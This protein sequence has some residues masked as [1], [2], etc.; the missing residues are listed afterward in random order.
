V[1]LYHGGEAQ[2]PVFVALGETVR[3][4]SLPAEPFHDLVR[5][6][7]QDQSVAR[8]E[9]W[10]ALFGYCRYSANPVGRLVLYLCGYRDEHRQSLSDS[11]CTALQLAN[12]WQDVAV[13]LNKDRIYLPLAVLRKHGA[14]VED[15][16]ALRFTP[17]IREA[18]REAVEVARG[19]FEKGLPL[20][21]IV[22][23]RLSLDLDLFSR[24]GLRILRKI[25][26]Q[27]YNVLSRRPAV[28]KGERAML[29]LG[30]LVR[31][32]TRRAA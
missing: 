22:N 11:T 29:L 21:G 8:Y 15:V 3:R 23:R 4:H 30:A 5:A 13:D 27:N 9:D 6:F 10:D 16:I 14:Q 12:F 17:Q 20:A 28:S 25:E 19:L 26:E 1:R 7:V 24:G 32:A 18:M 2:K 31:M